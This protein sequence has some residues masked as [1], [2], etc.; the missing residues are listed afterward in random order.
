MPS[1]KDGLIVFRNTTD[2]RV[3]SC[4]G[5][6][7]WPRVNCV[8]SGDRDLGTKNDARRRD[9]HHP[10]RPTTVVVT[11]GPFR[12]SRNPLYLAL[13]FLYLGLT[14]AFNMWWGRSFFLL[15]CIAE[16]SFAR[17]AT[18]NRSL[19][20]PIGGIV[21]RLEDI[22]EVGSKPDDCVAHRLCQNSY[23]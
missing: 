18:L 8:R 9:E 2:L 4:G 22:C 15:S 14:F 10:L 5:S 12:F 23:R 20:R 16:L 11:T 17:S 19:V 7:V 1:F 21:L 13:T 6:L 3:W